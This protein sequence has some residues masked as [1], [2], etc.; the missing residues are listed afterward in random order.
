MDRLL[1]TGYTVLP[2]PQI[3]PRLVDEFLREQV[4]YTAPP[5][6]GYTLGGF[7]AFGNPSSFHHPHIRTIKS[8]ASS[9]LWGDF[10]TTF[11]GRKLQVLFD[12]FALRKQGTSPTAESWHRDESS[13]SLPGDR[14]LGGWINL[15][16]IPQEFSCIPNTHNVEPG[17]GQFNTFS[18][19]QGVELRPQRVVVTIPPGHILLFWQ[20][21]I[22]EVSAKKAK[23]DNARLFMGW[24]LTEHDQ[25]PFN[26]LEAIRTQG[27]PMIP[28]GQLPPIY[29]KLHWACWRSRVTELTQCVRPEMIDPRTQEVYRFMPS[30]ESSGLPMFREYTDDEIALH[31]VRVL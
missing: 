22:H 2:G 9:H 18:K 6:R 4:E 16:T 28:S 13:V 27:I 11:P 8:I 31:S 7:G 1:T 17:R 29:A 30:L 20:H 21:L 5:P 25:D 12:R 3:P 15:S 14:I 23:C 24:R 26:Y 19:E 10:Q